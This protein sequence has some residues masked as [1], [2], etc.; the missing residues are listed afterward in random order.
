MVFDL[1][2]TLVDSG[3]DI[4]AAANH[5]LRL[6]G[7]PE[8]PIRDIAGFVGDGAR[9]LMERASRLPPESARLDALLASFLEYYTDHPAEHTRPVDGADACLA[10]LRHRLPL[11]I[12]TNK[13]RAATAALLR[14]LE[15]SDRF[16]AVV[17]GG[18]TPEYKPAPAPLQL[19]AARLQVSP[20]DLVMVGDGPQDI[21]SGRAVGC[22]TVGIPGPLIPV[23]R[24]LDAAPDH[25]IRVL[26]DLL[27]LLQPPS[28]PSAS[29][30]VVSPR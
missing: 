1:D 15:W 22:L 23:A 6:H 16:D 8:L 25:V 18:D 5:A 3:G 24:L 2:G 14:A 19:V 12:C 20:A 17:A 4:A 28:L 26:A 10:A 29:E 21:E 27:P 9:R 7:L 11:A 13:P 30:R